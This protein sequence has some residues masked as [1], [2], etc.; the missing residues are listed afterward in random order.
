MSIKT[1]LAKATT[2]LVLVASFT[3]CASIVSGTRQEVRVNSSPSGGNIK[4]D[5]ALAGTTPA[6]LELSSKESHKLTIELQGYKP[7]DIILVQK[8][9]G[10]IFGNI[11]FG[12]LIGIA[13]DI[14]DGAAYAL[15]PNKIDAQLVPGKGAKC[16]SNPQLTVKLVAKAD[17]SWQRIGQLQRD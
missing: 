12:G 4:V 3:G 8:T 7:Y 14:S 6:V 17:P 15:S 1:Y 9:N 10:W 16:T 11:F 5:G 13:V 2:A